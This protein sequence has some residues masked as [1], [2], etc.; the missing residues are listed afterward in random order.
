MSLFSL[1][2]DSIFVNIEQGKNSPPLHVPSMLCSFSTLMAQFRV[3]VK[4]IT[5]FPQIDEPERKTEHFYLLFP[6]ANKLTHTNIAL[7][8]TISRSLTLTKSHTYM[9][10]K[11]MSHKTNHWYQDG[12]SIVDEH[13]GNKF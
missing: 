2:T 1:Y 5:Y 7:I 3:V 11:H 9:N 8:C 4:D 10:M 13:T 12:E 6:S